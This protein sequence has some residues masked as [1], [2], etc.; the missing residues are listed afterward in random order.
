MYAR[1]QTV[2]YFGHGIISF[3]HD[4]RSRQ[5]VHRCGILSTSWIGLAKT[6]ISYWIWQFT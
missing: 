3:G 2:L 4:Q 1:R 6:S 5:K